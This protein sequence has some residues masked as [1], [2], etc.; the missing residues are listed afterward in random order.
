MERWSP[1]ALPSIQA[2]EMFRA[3]CGRSDPE[4]LATLFDGNGDP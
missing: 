3:S 4:K 2:A 1:V